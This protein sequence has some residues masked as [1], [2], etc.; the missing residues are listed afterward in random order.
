MLY[1]ML[2]GLDFKLFLF[3]NISEEIVTKLDIT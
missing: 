3:L 2:Y 1:D